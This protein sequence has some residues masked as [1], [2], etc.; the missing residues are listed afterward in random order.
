MTHLQ[1]VNDSTCADLWQVIQTA[2]EEYRG[3]LD[4][5]SGVFKETVADIQHKVREGGGFLAFVESEIA[6]GVV[7]EPRDGYLYL[8]RLAVLPNFR[9]Q[10]ISRA[11]VEAVEQAARQL[12]LPRVRVGVRIVLPDNV[13]M[14]ERLG[15]EIVSYDIHPGYTEPTYISMDKNV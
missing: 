12:N 9:G 2:F 1:P 5:P 10:G 8:G 11:L 6:G 14:F 15:Y 4:P 7:Y 3:K 13:A